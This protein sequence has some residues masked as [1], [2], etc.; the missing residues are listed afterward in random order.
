[1]N[2]GTGLNDQGG[3]LSISRST[4]FNNQGGGILVGASA[5]PI[6]FDITN[7]FIYRNG[8]SGGASVGG[9]SLV[10][11]AGGST[12]NRFEFNTVVDNQVKDSA[13]VAGGVLCDLGAFHAPNNLI[14]RNSVGGDATKPNANMLGACTYPSSTLASAVTGFNFKTSEASPYD[15]HIQSGSSVIGKATTP[16]TVT[17][18]FDNQPRPANAGDQG[19]D[20]YKP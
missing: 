2:E 15:Y 10:P 3:S 9:V 5:T 4:F 19:A 12:P 1:M 6:A 14:A 11:G 18:D 13:L 20:Q 8:D 16:S 17:V 7:T